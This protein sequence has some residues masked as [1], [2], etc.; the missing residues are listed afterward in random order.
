MATPGD[1]LAAIQLSLIASSILAEYSVVRSWA[2]ANDGYIRI[3]ATLVNGDFLEA[4]EYF[5]QD[6]SGFETADYRH[7][8]MDPTKTKLRRRW[9]CTPDHPQL[10]NFPHHVHIEREDKVQESKPIG[11]I[12]LLQLLEK[13]LAQR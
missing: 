7:Q 9:D 13:L 6:Q 4:A 1:H 8:W 5:V 2:D 10:P 11:L 12:D 3:R